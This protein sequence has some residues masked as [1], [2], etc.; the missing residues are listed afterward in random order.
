M[1]IIQKI[2]KNPERVKKILKIMLKEGFIK[3]INKKYKISG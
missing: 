3:Q 2:D 1:D